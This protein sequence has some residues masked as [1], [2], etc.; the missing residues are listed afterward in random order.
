MLSKIPNLIEAFDETKIFTDLNDAIEYYNVCLFIQN[1]LWLTTWSEEFTE[2]LKSLVK[3]ILG[4]IA[5]CF[6][7]IN[8]GNFNDLT[9]QVND[10]YIDDY[11][12]LLCKFDAIKKI[13]WG[14]F[15]IAMQNKPICLYQVLLHKKNVDQYS[16]NLRQT[17]LST[18][19]NAELILSDLSA[20]ISPKSI[21][22]YPKELTKA[23]IN[24]LFVEYIN[25]S[26]PNLNYLTQ[27]VNYRNGSSP[28]NITKDLQYAAKQ[29]LERMTADFFEN[30]PGHKVEC[31]VVFR[32]QRDHK[33]INMEGMKI[34]LS[35]DSNWIKDNLDFLTILYNFIYLFEFLDSQF[36][37]ATLS[38]PHSGSV[39]DYLIGG[40]NES[41]YH[42]SLNFNITNGIAVTQ[43]RGYYFELK[44]H[45]VLLE[46]V[47][48]WYYTVYLDQ[49][50]GIKDFHI[51]FP[52]S[53]ASYLERCKSIAPEIEAI[54]KQYTSLKKF[55]KIDHPYI[56]NVNPAI[57][58]KNLPSLCENNYAYPK[59]QEIF[60]AM[61]HLFS[62]QSMCHY[63]EE[64]GDA[65]EN[66]LFDQIQKH[67]IKYSSFTPWQIPIID[68]LIKLNF[69]Q[70]TPNEGIIQI[71]DNHVVII[72]KQLYD[73]GFVNTLNYPDEMRMS[74]D[75]LL[76]K[77]VNIIR[78][79]KGLL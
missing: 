68:E 52:A 53:D 61:F 64:L 15:S 7:S 18:P 24:S 57:A 31:V 55:N 72:L 5:R 32:P 9:S 36:R 20:S 2:N 4:D 27:I 37:I 29:K 51:S 8:D 43:F 69:L 35:Y 56:E 65:N 58:Y 67:K 63:V 25:S 42:V 22:F 44:R 30:Q 17:I 62:D 38:N 77:V 50:F 3:P 47:I 70:K 21:K 19:S 13:S 10:G 46:E 79:G 16:E 1:G 34:T 49:E 41:D 60:T 39:M 33:L 54:L 71:V 75:E 73:V 48:R 76:S 23:D 11:L 28:Y 74:L 66:C 59:S 26:E 14:S 78:H 6:A 12:C 40:R 45:G